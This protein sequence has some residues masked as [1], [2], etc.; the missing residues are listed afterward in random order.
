MTEIKVQS[1][2]IKDTVQKFMTTGKVIGP[3]PVGS[4]IYR[5]KESDRFDAYTFLLVT[6]VQT[7]FRW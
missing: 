3:S 4:D 1:I 5:T 7:R 2:I 6:A